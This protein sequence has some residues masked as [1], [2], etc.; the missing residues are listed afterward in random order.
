MT[1]T[2]KGGIKSQIV[3]ILNLYYWCWAQVTEILNSGHKVF[4]HCFPENWRQARDWVWKNECLL[5]E[6][7]NSE[8]TTLSWEKML[9]NCFIK[10]FTVDYK[11]ECDGGGCFALWTGEVGCG[12]CLFTLGGI[13][14]KHYICP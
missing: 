11:Q 12:G 6:E 2:N 7:A 14:N 8:T 5:L 13:Q 4:W 10:F 3:Y 1:A 9:K